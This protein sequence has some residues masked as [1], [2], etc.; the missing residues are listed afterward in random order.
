MQIRRSDNR[1]IR[2][3]RENN[4]DAKEMQEKC[5]ELKTPKRTAFPPRIG[6]GVERRGRALARLS[7]LNLSKFY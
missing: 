7:I 1:E 2:E 3:I 5:K 6:G 4:T